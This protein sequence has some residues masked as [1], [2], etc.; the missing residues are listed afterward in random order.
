MTIRRFLKRCSCF[1]LPA[2]FLLTQSQAYWSYLSQGDQPLLWAPSANFQR[3]LKRL[4]I[5][6]TPFVFANSESA[7]IDQNEAADRTDLESAL[8]SKGEFDRQRLIETYLEGRDKIKKYLE[9]HSLWRTYR[10]YHE[11]GEETKTIPPEFPVLRDVSGL[12][13]EFQL[14]LEGWAAFHQGD[15][16]SARARWQELLSLPRHERKFRSTW[17]AYMIAKSWLSE[18]PQ[19]AKE[20][21]QLVRALARSGYKDALELA[22]A[23]YGWEGRAELNRKNYAA[24]LAHY[25]ESYGARDPAAEISVKLVIDDIVTD[26][27]DLLPELSRNELARRVVTAHLI[28][29]FYPWHRGRKPSAATVWLKAMEQAN[30]KEPQLLEQLA[31]A[32]YQSSEWHLAKGWTDATKKQSLVAQWLEAKLLLR[33]E[34]P[35]KAMAILSRIAPHM[36]AT[37]HWNEIPASLLENLQ[38]EKWEGRSS[39][40]EHVHGELG[41]LHLSRREYPQALQNLLEHDFQ[42][43]AAYLAER[44][45]TLEEL[46]NFVESNFPPQPHLEPGTEISEQEAKLRSRTEFIRSLLGRRLVR[47]FQFAVAKAY[48]RPEENEVLE[49]FEKF[50]GVAYSRAAPVSDR[51]EAFWGAAQLLHKEGSLIFGTVTEPWWRLWGEFHEFERGPLDRPAKLD[52]LVPATPDELRRVEEHKPD[53]RRRFHLDYLAA[54]LAWKA[55]ELLPS[56]SDQTARILHGGGTWIKHLDPEE[57]D[58][59]YKALVRRCRKTELGQAADLKRW[60][61]LLDEN[62]NVVYPLR[63]DRAP[64]VTPASE[65]DSEAG[66]VMPDAAELGVSPVASVE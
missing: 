51:A 26:A 16:A 1:L 15:N 65:M 9:T 4:A 25:I 58:R 5:P 32:A 43:D 47:A 64:D 22:A 38:I 55:A 41:I 11:H 30:I 59:F 53:K 12:P 10:T 29:G 20:H 14:Y 23:T 66:Q 13:A 40:A 34:Q 24:A 49:R 62:G 42:K 33:D 57:A 63:K 60:F 27:P 21:F 61:P 28:S 45:L 44:V 18:D 56:N 46:Q 52:N 50:W 2:L 6:A 19:K 3:E 54:D 31:L 48:F 37:D 17:A 7:G 8:S 39:I 35:T 36:P